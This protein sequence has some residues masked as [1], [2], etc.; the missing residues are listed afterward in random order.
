M[1]Q[2]KF[3]TTALIN[4]P[5]TDHEEAVA[6]VKPKKPWDADSPAGVKKGSLE[7]WKLS[8]TFLVAKTL[9]LIFSVSLKALKTI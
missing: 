7:Y 1:Q 3:I 9:K 2:D 6:P 5:E 4:G 8:S